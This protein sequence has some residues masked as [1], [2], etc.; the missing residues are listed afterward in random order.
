MTTPRASVAAIVLTVVASTARAQGTAPVKPEHSEATKIVVFLAG[1]AAGLVVHE[2]GHVLFSLTFDANPRVSGIRYG[3]LPFFAIIHDPVPRRQEFIISSAGFWMQH[4]GS[5][6][7]LTA[8]PDL[9]D[10]QAPFLKG[11]FAFNLAASAVYASAAF[12]TYGPPQRDTRGMAA[13]LG[14]DGVREPIV[15]FLVLGPAVLDGYRYLHPE[16][17]WAKWAS[18]SVKIGLVALSMA[19]GR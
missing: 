6:W 17:S 9:K 14:H 18:R 7:L 19:A 12:G 11:I 13:T 10:E 15:G 8:R 4:A 2:S 5:E 3:P 16:A 1:A